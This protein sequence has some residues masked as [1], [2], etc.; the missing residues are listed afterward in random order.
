MPPTR[1]TRPSGSVRAG[2][3]S[4]TLTGTFGITVVSIIV[5]NANLWVKVGGLWSATIHRSVSGT[6]F[7]AS[8]VLDISTVSTLPSRSRHQVSSSVT[9]ILL[10]LVRAPKPSPASMQSL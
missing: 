5:I 6:Y 7:S 8:M 10:V 9:P 4:L 2:P 1:K 3:I